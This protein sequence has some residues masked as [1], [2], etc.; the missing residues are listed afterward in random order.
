MSVAHA[1]SDGS[2]CPPIRS[3]RQKAPGDAAITVGRRPAQQ[4]SAARYEITVACNERELQQHL[5]AWHELTANAAEPNAYY[6]PWALQPAL[7]HLGDGHDIRVL[8]VY[9]TGDPRHPAPLLCGLMPW[10]RHRPMP[11]V[12]FK[13]L[14]PW[15][16]P[17]CFFGTPLLRRG[18]EVETLEAILSWARRDPLGAPVVR[19][20]Q[21]SGDGPFARALAEV[22][23]RGDRVTHLLED[24]SR[25]VITPSGDAEAYLRGS[26]GGRQA[27]DYRRRKRRLTELGE[28]EYRVL[29]GAEEVDAWAEMFLAL[30]CKGWK[31]RLGTAMA[32]APPDAA[33]FR[34]MCRGAHAASRLMMLGIFLD[35]E[36][37]AL[38]CNLRSGRGSFA[39]KVAY[40]EDYASHSPGWLLELFNIELLHSDGDIEWMDSCTGPDNPI[41]RIWR[42][43]RLITNRWVST[44]RPPG[45]LLVALMP[46]VSWLR[47]KTRRRAIAAST[48]DR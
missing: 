2:P 10:R 16:H 24:Y 47:R 44:G 6:E 30:E 15:L 22:C 42:E 41:N 31:G 9:L 36:P 12:P 7:H 34:D 40:D 20:I 26:L 32:C 14:E 27:K 43:R 8:L 37:L 11:G 48:D 4:T 38:Q 35:G 5:D 19:F 25:A 23:R 45:D 13:A 46:L 17:Y 18:H 39:F 33:F 21:V 1:L 3:G 29:T 28:V